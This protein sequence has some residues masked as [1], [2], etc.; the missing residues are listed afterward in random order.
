MKPFP[1]LLSPKRLA[2]ALAALAM[3][4]SAACWN[5]NT[6]ETH[7][8]GLVEFTLPAFPETGAHAA[9]VFT[10][11]HYQPWHRV[12][13]VPRLLPPL[14]SVPVTG[15][16]IAYTKDEYATL[17]APDPVRTAYSEA[18]A[19]ELFRVNCAVCH[20]ESMTGDGVMRGF[21]KSGA[22][23]ADLMRG[24]VSTASEGEVFAWVSF[25]GQPGFAMAMISR[26]SPTV[27]P[28]FYQLLTEEERWHLVLYLKQ[29]SA[30]Q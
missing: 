16:A 21:L 17:T 18:K 15:K 19:A 26:E 30:A 24:A 13:E 7:V 23:P 6:G 22:P 27:M 29:K 12:Q 8:G 28:Q 11:M 2:V 1:A 4:A 10:E 20:G 5:N 9:L 14:E 3:M 25:G